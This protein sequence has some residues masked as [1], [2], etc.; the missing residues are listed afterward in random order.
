[1]TRKITKTKQRFQK[2][3]LLASGWE[4]REMA[5]AHKLKRFLDVEDVLQYGSLH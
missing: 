2:I 1:M 5:T 4:K 3:Y